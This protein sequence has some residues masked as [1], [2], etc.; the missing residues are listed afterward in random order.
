MAI[1]SAKRVANLPV[2]SDGELLGIVSI[3]DLVRG[4]ISDREF[5]I[6]QLEHYIRR[7]LLSGTKL[8]GFA[9]LASLV[10]EPAC[11]CSKTTG[12]MPRTPP[13]TDRLSAVGEIASRL[14]ARWR[15]QVHEMPL[16]HRRVSLQF[17]AVESAGT[18]SACC[19]K[20]D[21]GRPT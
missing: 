11:S 14:T 20:R 6:E 8:G 16:M 18:D 3:G 10:T 1:I 15:R 19:A 4:I 12:Q 13:F 7:Y 2:I 21:A 5:V 9:I 17:V